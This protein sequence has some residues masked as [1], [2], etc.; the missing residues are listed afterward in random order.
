MLRF[1][2]YVVKLFRPTK[3]IQYAAYDRQLKAVAI[4]LLCYSNERKLPEVG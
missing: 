4:K 1:E 2:T 3:K